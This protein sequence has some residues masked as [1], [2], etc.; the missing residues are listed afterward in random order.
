MRPKLQVDDTMLEIVN[1]VS[2]YVNEDNKTDVYVDF[3]TIGG[4]G[5]LYKVNDTKF[6]SILCNEYRDRT[7][8]VALP[9]FKPLL[10]IHCQD[11][12]ATGSPT[13]EPNRRLFGSLNTRQ[14]YYSYGG[15]EKFVFI[16]PKKWALFSY[17][18]LKNRKFIPGPVDKPQVEPVSGGDYL[19]LL[20]PYINLKE[21][22]FKLLAINI[23]QLFSHD[24]SH[25]ALILSSA[26][27]TGKSTLTKLIQ[28]LVD[29]SLIEATVMTKREEDLKVHLAGTYLACFDNTEYLRGDV[30]NLLCSAITGTGMAKR[31]LYTTAKIAA[32]KIHNVIVLNGIN[33]IP[34]KS[35]LIDRSLLFELQPISKNARKTDGDFWDSFNKDKPAILG[36]IFDVL[37]KAMKIV[38][39]LTIDESPRMAD[40]Y[41]EMLAIALALDIPQ[42]EFSRIFN[43]NIDR[44]QEAYTQGNRFVEHVLEFMSKRPAGIKASAN[45]VYDEMRSSIVGDSSFF[46][47]SASWLSRRLNEEQD[48]LFN[49]GYDFKTVKKEKANY[50]YITPVPKNRQTKA[51]KEAI[52]DRAKRQADG[53]ADGEADDEAGAGE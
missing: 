50:I 20:R 21:D 23:A 37:V 18:K 32:F 7:G 8:L 47:S 25:Y 17:T 22:D 53:E 11:V 52:A 10:T 26:K 41:K 15:K 49:A 12:I 9:D 3:K 36:A 46:P 16:A 4:G 34:Q 42:D 43:S 5:P 30:S 33:I 28:E 1:D 35:D 40:A 48:A 2:F 27:G 24:C 31:E 13:V 45:T 19:K 44:L 14:I 38:K 51:Q 6:L 29:P 39:N